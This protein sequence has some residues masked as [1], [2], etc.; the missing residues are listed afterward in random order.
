MN[1]FSLPCVQISYINRSD[2]IDVSEEGRKAFDALASDA[3]ATVYL[4]SK[5]VLDWMQNEYYPEI[6]VHNELRRITS[7]PVMVDGIIKYELTTRSYGK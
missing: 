1:L 5:A 2:D 7:E 3:G 4:P 6:F